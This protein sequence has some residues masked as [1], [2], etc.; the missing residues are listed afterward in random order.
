MKIIFLKLAKYSLIFIVVSI[1][2]IL[3]YLFF[4]WF[5]STLTTTPRTY[6]CDKPHII[7]ASSNGVHMDLIFHKDLLDKNFLAELSPL[8]GRE[9]IAI[10]WG[11]KGFYLHTPSWA[12]LKV[13]TAISAA[14][15]PSTTLMH[16]THYKA[17]NP[18]WKSIELCTE[19]LTKLNQFVEASFKRNAANDLQILEGTGY[20][21]NDF[22]YEAKGNY[23]CLYTCNVWVN[24]AL[25]KADVKTAVWSPFDKGIMKHL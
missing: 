25:K 5:L 10:G 15:L 14:F 1:A 9:Y 6:S 20:R 7:Y 18:K 12:E 3:N 24:Q 13:S 23:T 11:D 16:V 4:A 21:A 22:F 8:E 2:F 19:Q 17:V